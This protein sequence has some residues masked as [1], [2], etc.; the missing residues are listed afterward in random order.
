MS[1]E[2]G[3]QLAVVDSRS[4]ATPPTPTKG[5]GALASFEPRDMKQLWWLCTQLV[6]TGFLPKAIQAPGQAV[7]VILAGKDLGLSAMQSLRGLN[8]I[9]GK[10]GLNADMMLALLIRGGV[11]HQWIESNEKV[12]TLKVERP[13]FEPL[14]YSYSMEMAERAGLTKASPRTGAASNFTK[15]PAAMLR[16][17]CVSAV[18]RAYAPDL[19]MGIYLP[20]ELSGDRV[21][22]TDPPGGGDFAEFTPPPA[23]AAA[24]E[25]IDQAT[26]EVQEKPLESKAAPAKGLQVTESGTVLVPAAPAPAK[27]SRGDRFLDAAGVPNLTE[28]Q[29]LAAEPEPQRPSV[30]EEMGLPHANQA[31]SELDRI[32]CAIQESPNEGVLLTLNREIN[33]LGDEDRG[34]ARQALGKRRAELNRGAA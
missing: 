33:A 12:A 4:V 2:N 27:K 10:I 1:N 20:E 6:G 34:K 8:I 5:G 9:E 16:A 23:P 11:R 26:S 28:A 7:A 30:A 19:A 24:A 18:A 29:R 25:V 14:T 3:T 22:P 15:H 32:L 13:G 17:R 21:P 31:P